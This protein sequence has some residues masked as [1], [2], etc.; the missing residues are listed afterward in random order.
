MSEKPNRNF[1]QKQKKV[2]YKSVPKK[3]KKQ[4]RN[5]ENELIGIYKQGQGNFGFIDTVDE[6]TGE[7]QGYFCHE[8][9]KLDAFEGDEVAFELQYF[10]GKPEA[11]IKKVIK[12]SEHLIV[13]KL[14]ISKGCAFVVSKNPLIKTDIFIPGKHIGGYTDGSQ[15]AVQ[16]IKWE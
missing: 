9:K 14:Q 3:N 1:K 2:F 15:V 10:R 7:K 12:R 11:I 4:K 8:S 6:K 16:I 5:P 13:G